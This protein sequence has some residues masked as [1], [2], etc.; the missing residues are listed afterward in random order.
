FIDL[1]RARIANIKRTAHG[2]G[3]DIELAIPYDKLATAQ[4]EVPD[5]QLVLVGDRWLAACDDHRVISVRRAIDPAVRF[6]DGV[7]IAR[8]AKGG[9]TLYVVAVPHKDAVLGMDIVAGP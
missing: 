5:A 6:L 4:I 2:E 7:P 1:Q 8:S 3:R 9:G